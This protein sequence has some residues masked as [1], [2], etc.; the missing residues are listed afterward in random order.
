LYYKQLVKIDLSHAVPKVAFW[1]FSTL[2]KFL[3]TEQVRQVLRHCERTTP[4]GRRDYAILLLLARLGLRAGEVTRLNLEDIDWE[5]SRITVLGKGQRRTQFPLPADAGKAIASYLHHGRPRCASRRVFI[6]A[7]APFRG[8][9]QGNIVSGIVKDNLARA[10]VVVPG[11]KGAHLLRHSL[12]TD[13]LRKGASLDEIGE[14]L[15]HKCRDTTAIYAKV[16]FESL[17]ALALPW[18]GGG[19]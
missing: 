17:R 10:G 19:K 11:R 8:F 15:R 14:V 9:S 12:A 6:R 3:S 4:L 1:S 13:M 18:P 5:N 2:P 16:D 7:L